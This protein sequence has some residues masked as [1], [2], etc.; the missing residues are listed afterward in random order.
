MLSAMDYQGYDLVAS[1]DMSI[2]TSEEYHE[3]EDIHLSSCLRKLIMVSASGYVV[4]RKS[5]RKGEG[6]R[7]SPR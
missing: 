5:G 6:L 2:G 1:I 3:G 7:C 4:L